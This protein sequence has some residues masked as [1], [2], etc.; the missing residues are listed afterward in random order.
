MQGNFRV[1][2][3][4]GLTDTLGL[5]LTGIDSMPDKMNLHFLK[6]LYCEFQ[7]YKAVTTSVVGGQAKETHKS[8]L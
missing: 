2:C 5:N 3:N 4:L 1:R 6:V 8:Q 7:M